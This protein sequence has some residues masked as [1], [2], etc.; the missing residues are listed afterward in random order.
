MN[1]MLL[2]IPRKQLRSESVKDPFSVMLAKFVAML[3]IKL[4]I[5]I[6]VTVP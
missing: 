6:M 1:V 2:M 4:G 5:F 3:R